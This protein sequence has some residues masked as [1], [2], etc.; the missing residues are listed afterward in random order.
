MRE[1]TGSTTGSTDFDLLSLSLSFCLFPSPWSR[2]SF[3]SRFQSRVTCC[4]FLLTASRFSVLSLSALPV[5]PTRRTFH[6]P[7]SSRRLLVSLY[8]AFQCLRGG[9]TV[10][11]IEGPCTCNGDLPRICHGRSS[12]RKKLRGH[13][14]FLEPSRRPRRQVA[15][16]SSAARGKIKEISPAVKRQSR[17]RYTG[18]LGAGKF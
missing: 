4:P 17:K 13:F 9:R 16:D 12:P 5:P 18:F 15:R 7:P 2:C 14:V 1:E 8:V 10:T 6:L 11:A 3:A